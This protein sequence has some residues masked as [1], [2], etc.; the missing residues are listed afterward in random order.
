MQRSASLH[1]LPERPGTFVREL[2]PNNLRDK[3]STIE[4]TL[5]VAER[6]CVK[7]FPKNVSLPRL[8][9]QKPLLRKQNVSEKADKKLL[10]LRNKKCFR[11][12]LGR[13]N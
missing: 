8:W 4:E 13:A 5:I 1:K 9:A 6:H 11:R 12:V 2:V 7:C 10:F 3:A